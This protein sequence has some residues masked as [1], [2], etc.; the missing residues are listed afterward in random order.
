MTEG[1]HQMIAQLTGFLF[2]MVI[3]I[4]VS[5]MANVGYIQ[6]ENF[7]NRA[8]IENFMADMLAYGTQHD[9]FNDPSDSKEQKF[10]QVVDIY[11]AKY[12]IVEGE[13]ISG[14]I[15]FT[16]AINSKVWKNR[17]AEISITITPLYQKLDPINRGTFT[18]NPKTLKDITQGYVKTTGTKS[19]EYES[20]IISL[21]D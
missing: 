20:P 12:H 16:P 5:Y 7:R 13:T 6:Y 21:S 9:G 4:G 1:A 3:I 2:K 11:K 14:A 18:G 10:Q 17:N 15:V 8:N 19:Y